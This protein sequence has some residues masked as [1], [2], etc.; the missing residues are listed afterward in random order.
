MVK[1]FVHLKKNGLAQAP[2][3]A[4]LTHGPRHLIWGLCA[5]RGCFVPRWSYRQPV[6]ALESGQA[7]QSPLGRRWGCLQSVRL[8]VIQSLGR[9]RRRGVNARA[10]TERSRLPR[11]K[12]RVVT[13]SLRPSPLTDPPGSGGSCAGWLLRRTPASSG[14]VFV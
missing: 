13:P 8:P 4:P 12:L 3:T 7:C 10:L 11:R 2:H 14:F 5:V 9:L 1:T 6:S